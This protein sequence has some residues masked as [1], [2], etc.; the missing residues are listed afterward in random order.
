MQADRRYNLTIMT[1]DLTAAASKCTARASSSFFSACSGCMCVSAAFLC[2]LCE[3]HA[4]HG[5]VSCGWC[6]VCAHSTTC[7]ARERA[8]MLLQMRKQFPCCTYVHQRVATDQTP[9][10][11][12]SLSGIP[13]PVLVSTLILCG[14][15]CMVLALLVQLVVHKIDSQQMCLAAGCMWHERMQGMWSAASMGLCA[16]PLWHAMLVQPVASV[17][18]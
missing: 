16:D 7:H 5:C 4:C 6:H 15:A 10:L 8:A 9:S 14:P 18:Q 17:L 11:C 12:V 1:F 2:L 13:A 3:C